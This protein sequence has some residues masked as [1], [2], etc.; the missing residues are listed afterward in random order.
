M[1]IDQEQLRI[2]ERK[3]KKLVYEIRESIRKKDPAIQVIYLPNF[4]LS[5]KVDYIFITPE[6]SVRWAKNE[7]DAMIK[8]E[9]GFRNFMFS[10]EDIIFHYCIN[11]YL[12]DSYYITDISKA[13]MNTKDALKYYSWIFPKWNNLLKEEIGIIGKK[14]CKIIAVGWKSKEYLDKIELAT[15]QI[16]HYSPNAAKYRKCVPEKYPNEYKEFK[17][18]ISDEIILDFAYNFLNKYEKMVKGI[19]KWA[20]DNLD[21]NQ[22]VL[23]ESIKMLMFTYYKEFKEIK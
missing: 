5:K 12:S 23:T 10:K 19:G 7:K 11:K 18:I 21:K 9:N 3:Q 17:K 16:L 2:L 13:A 1:N 6:P 8:I 4:P 22:V 15:K 14:D 20:I